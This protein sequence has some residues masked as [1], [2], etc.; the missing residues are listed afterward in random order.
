L[1]LCY[2]EPPSNFGFKF[3]LRRYDTGSTLAASALNTLAIPFE[4]DQYYANVSTFDAACGRGLHSL[5][6]LELNLS[7]SRTHSSVKFGYTVDRRAQVELK[8]ERL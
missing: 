7:N 4:P 2:N 1:K 5:L 3:N 8:W 6:T